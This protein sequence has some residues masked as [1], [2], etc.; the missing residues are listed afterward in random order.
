MNI[1]EIKCAT[2]VTWMKR[3]YLLALFVGTG[4]PLLYALRV[5][6]FV[7]G[8]Y[9]L[10]SLAMLIFGLFDVVRKERNTMYA[11][12][13]LFFSYVLVAVYGTALFAAV[14]GIMR[15]ESADKYVGNT[16]MFSWVGMTIIFFLCRMPK[17]FKTLGNHDEI[18]KT[19]EEDR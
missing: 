6:P 17:A 5:N 1:N 16:V 9:S 10:V 13:F 4:V 7:L 8:G 11:F 3:P 19:G 2:G 18:H 12:Y 14:F 15:D